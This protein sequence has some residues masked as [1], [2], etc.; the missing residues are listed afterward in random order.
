MFRQLFKDLYAYRDLLLALTSRDIRVRY[1]Q[2]VMGIAWAF[3]LPL[4]AIVSG[5]VIRLAMAHLQNSELQ[6]DQVS[7]VMVRSVVWLLFAGGVGGCA[8]S[9]LTNIGL[10]TKIYFPREVLP[11]SSLLGR[12]F[13]FGISA[14]GVVISIIILTIAAGSEKHV[15]TLSPALLLVIPQLLVVILMIAGAGM[16][17]AAAN[18]FFRDVKYI[19]DVM[20]RFGIFFSGVMIFMSDLPVAVRPYF[21]LNPL[22][23]LMEGISGAVV[24]GAIESYLWP[25][26]LYSVLVT[27]LICWLGVAS[28]RRGEH[29][30]AEYA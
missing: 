27:V 10:V 6:W 5:V 19:V 29:L 30:F 16:A 2:A 9:L 28:F 4:L 21:L 15:I 26:L 1:K 14:V 8:L 12:L 3:F 24:N 22:V 11:I 23:P 13:D 18:V 20:L 7:A 17:L 25:W